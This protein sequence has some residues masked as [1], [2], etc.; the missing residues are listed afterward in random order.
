MHPDWNLSLFH[1]RNQGAD[2]GRVLVGLQVPDGA[3][4]REFADSLGY[5]WVDETEN[6]VYR[7]F[8]R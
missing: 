4:F 5:P 1:Y 3:V 8:L 7:L 6:P 2:Y